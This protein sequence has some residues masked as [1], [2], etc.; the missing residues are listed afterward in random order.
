MSW[1]S[2]L[3]DSY[4]RLY[5]RTFS[6]RTVKPTYSAYNKDIIP[7]HLSLLLQYTLV[8]LHM[9]C[10]V[11]PTQLTL[12]IYPAWTVEESQLFPTNSKLMREIAREKIYCEQ[13]CMQMK[14]AG[15]DARCS[16]SKMR[17]SQG[18]KSFLK[19]SEQDK[20]SSM[21]IRC[22]R[23]GESGRNHRAREKEH[24]L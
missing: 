12:P 22:A 19:Q 5:L 24:L 15:S 6:Y 4:S 9:Y 23:N 14:K 3:R 10:T 1:K 18:G 7:L 20:W 16:S 21:C 11:D 8:C 2:R 13:L 17:P